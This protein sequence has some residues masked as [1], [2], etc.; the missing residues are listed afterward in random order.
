[1]SEFSRAIE[2]SDRKHRNAVRAAVRWIEETGGSI[3]DAITEFELFP[4]DREMLKQLTA[5]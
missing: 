3:E 5:D 1:M 4:S 2:E